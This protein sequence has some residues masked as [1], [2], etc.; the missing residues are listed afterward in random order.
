MQAA[1]NKPIFLSVGEST[2]S[3]VMF[4]KDVRLLP[5]CRNYACF[6]REYGLMCCPSVCVFI[7]EALNYLP[8]SV[9]I[10]VKCEVFKCMFPL[11]LLFLSYVIVNVIV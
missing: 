10:S 4:V 2:S 8:K 1:Q 3:S 5:V 11:G 9:W 6:V 7:V